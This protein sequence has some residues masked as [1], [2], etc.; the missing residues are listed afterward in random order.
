[1]FERE[2][3]VLMILD[4]E[5]TFLESVGHVLVVMG[6]VTL[7]YVVLKFQNLDGNVLMSC[8]QSYVGCKACDT[9]S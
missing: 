8:G 6:F 4:M 9:G 1:M 5:K 7:E 2:A 3:L